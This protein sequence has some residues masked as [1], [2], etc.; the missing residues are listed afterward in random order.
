MSDEVEAELQFLYEGDAPPLV[1]AELA[2]LI[3]TVSAR[4][5]VIDTYYDTGA[6]GLRRA[7]CTLRVRQ[8]GNRTRPRLTWKGVSSRRGNARRR[9]ET[10]VP[11][12]HL[13]RNAAELSELL[14]ELKLWRRVRKAARASGNLALEEIGELHNDRSIHMYASGLLRLE[15]TWDRLRYPVG[16]QRRASKSRS[17]PKPPRAFSTTPDMNCIRSSTTPWSHPG[18]ERSASSAT[19]CTRTWQR[20]DRRIGPHEGNR[21]I[22]GE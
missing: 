5:H 1:P 9:P 10:E 15:L 14:V 12:E 2:N 3:L 21:G 22:N 4:M 18:E 13:P 7:G 6:L 16:P 20:V 19:G 11:L 8:A 17:N